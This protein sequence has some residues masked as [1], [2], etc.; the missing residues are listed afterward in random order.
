MTPRYPIVV[1]WSEE[2]GVWVAE[3]PDLKSCAA[4]GDSA[5]NAVA[6][7]NVAMTAWFEA[8]RRAGHSLP[9]P[10]TASHLLAAE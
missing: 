2:D 9:E 3:A 6:E 10:S 8:A 1:F 7:L 5:E 4:F